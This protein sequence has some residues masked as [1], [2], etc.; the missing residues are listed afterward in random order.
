M[1]AHIVAFKLTSRLSLEKRRSFAKRED[2]RVI[3]VNLGG[4]VGQ[5][6][7]DPQ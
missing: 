2:G 6:R 1:S 5:V 4:W 7:L 3:W